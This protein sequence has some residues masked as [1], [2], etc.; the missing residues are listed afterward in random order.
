M[1]LWEWHWSDKELDTGKSRESFPYCITM[2]TAYLFLGV[3]DQYLM[4]CIISCVC[5]YW[6]TVWWH[7]YCCCFAAVGAWSYF[8]F[9]VWDR[10]VVVLDFIYFLRKI[11]KFGE[12]KEES[13]ED[14]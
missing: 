14:C 8:V 5:F 6:I 12:Y 4:Y 2:K 10:F 13:L 11:L 7:F 9:L 3:A 1:K